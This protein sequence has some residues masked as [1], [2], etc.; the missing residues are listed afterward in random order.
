MNQYLFKIAAT[1]FFIFLLSTCVGEAKQ[2]EQPNETEQAL[3]AMRAAVKLQ[4]QVISQQAETNYDLHRRILQLEILLK[5]A[6]ERQIK[7]DRDKRTSPC[8]M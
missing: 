2:P 3:Y 5:E 4:N 7:L 1:F 8:P 6:A